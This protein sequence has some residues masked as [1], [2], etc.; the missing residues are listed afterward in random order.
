MLSV[1]LILLLMFS[2]SVTFRTLL[3][4]DCVQIAQY[5]Y[6]R[7]FSSTVYLSVK[8]YGFIRNL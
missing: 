7:F 2:T 4:I 3:F 8:G 1:V 5:V 6:C